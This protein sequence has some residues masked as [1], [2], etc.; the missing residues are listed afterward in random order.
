[1]FSSWPGKFPL[2]NDCIFSQS[3]HCSFSEFSGGNVLNPS[4]LSRSTYFINF[5]IN[6][7]S[8]CFQC[9]THMLS[10]F[11]SACEPGFLKTAGILHEGFFSPFL[12]F[13]FFDG[14]EVKSMSSILEPTPQWGELWNGFYSFS[15]SSPREFCSSCLQWSLA[16]WVM[17]LSSAFSLFLP[18]TLV[19][20]WINSPVNLQ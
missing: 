20:P 1:M 8:R 10:A 6:C 16:G 15:Q 4:P 7:S 9:P 3:L 19:F 5:S 12:S 17:H 18:H 2:L 13:F 11:T 14:L